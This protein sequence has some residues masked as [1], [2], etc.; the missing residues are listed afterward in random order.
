MPRFESPDAY[1]VGLGEVPEAI[2]ACQYRR[3][4]T[5]RPSD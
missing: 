5:R 4:T 2:P 1:P 3:L